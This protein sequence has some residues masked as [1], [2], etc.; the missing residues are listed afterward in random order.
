MFGSLIALCDTLLFVLT[1]DSS[2]CAILFLSKNMPMRTIA[3]EN[4][5]IGV[6][7]SDKINPEK[8]IP[9]TDVVENNKTVLTVPIIFN[10]IKK[11]MVVIPVPTNEII[12]IFGNC[13]NLISI[14]I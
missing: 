4:M 5:S 2:I 14:G 10:P 8:N 11:N 1:I 9:N 13:S 6:I 12:K 7:T 3:D